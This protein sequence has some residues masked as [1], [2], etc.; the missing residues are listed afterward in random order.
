MW[1]YKLILLSTVAFFSVVACETQ[2]QLAY[3]LARA[4]VSIYA[5]EAKVYLAE[6]VDL[7]EVVDV[8]AFGSLWPSATVAEA[9]ASL[10]SP[11]ESRRLPDGLY[12][13]YGRGVLLVEMRELSEDGTKSI[14]RWEI[15]ACPP[16]STFMSSVPAV[17]RDFVNRLDPRGEHD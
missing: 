7:R 17:L 16:T 5:H 10:G 3:P 6:G 4:E 9:K 15:R 14:P 1:P 8:S 2:V 11:V 12:T 13:K